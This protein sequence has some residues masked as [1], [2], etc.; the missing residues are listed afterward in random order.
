MKTIQ[1]GQIGILNLF[2][3]PIL[4]KL[5]LSFAL[6]CRNI[7][8]YISSPTKGR[9][10]LLLTDPFQETFKDPKLDSKSFS[11]LL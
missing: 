2:A 4:C 8:C 7:L 3:I 5:F 6:L 11:Y 9:C 10:I 1:Q